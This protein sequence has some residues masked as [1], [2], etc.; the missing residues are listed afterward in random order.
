MRENQVRSVA[1]LSVAV[2]VLTF[3]AD[4]LPDITFGDVSLKK[5]GLRKAWLK[6]EPAPLKNIPVAV[7][8]A[9]KD[10]V[11]APVVEK[12]YAGLEEFGKNNLKQ[13]FSAL[14]QARSHPV[15]VAFFGDSFIE[16]DI[17]CGPFRDTLQRLYGGRGV[18]YMPITS[19]VSRF[20]TSI[21]HEFANWR[22]YSVVGPKNASA[23]FATPGF[24]FKPDAGNQVMYKSAASPFPLVKLFYEAEFPA[25]LA[26]SV[27]DQSDTVS[28]AATAGLA[29]YTLPTKRCPSITLSF[30]TTDSLKVYGAA[31]EDSVGI[32]V[33]NFGVR[34][35]AGMG[36]FA[37]N[38]ER[39][40]QFNDFRQYKLVI[41]QYGLNV[42][43]EK[44]TSGYGWFGERMVMLVEHLRKSMPDAAF[45]LIGVGDRS[46]NQQGE[47]VTMP[48]VKQLRQVQRRAAQRAGIAFWDLYGA[49]GGE[50]SMKNYVTATPPLAARD[51]THLTFRGGRKL[52]KKLAD[53][54][55]MEKKKY[56]R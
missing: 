34:G 33:D 50:N 52:A 45:L 2:L 19:E 3:A 15:R 27:N 20:R 51:Y 8:S 48:G 29:Q 21:I 44:D 37:V 11:P 22:T 23:P 6:D 4:F 24:C 47:M 35:N 1:Y 42:L 10:S 56:D 32:S 26:Y 40:N 49:M 55:L 17:L 46:V 16:G 53:A 31:L 13:F 25:S 7:D 30:P 18:G 5:P 36:L 9:A 38:R 54:L 43:S 12:A 41:L 39:M 14:R 28:L